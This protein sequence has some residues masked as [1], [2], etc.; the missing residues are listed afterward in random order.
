MNA[1]AMLLAGLF[2][3]F[4]G[5]SRAQE[6]DTGGTGLFVHVGAVSQGSNG[7]GLKGGADFGVS[8]EHRFRSALGI[9]VGA[10]LHTGEL[11]STLDA[12]AI[13]LDLHGRYTWDLARL[14]PYLSAGIG[15][16]HLNPDDLPGTSPESDT[17]FGV[18]VAAGFDVPVRGGWRVGF[19]GAHHFVVAETS[20]GGGGNAMTWFTWAATV[21]FA[22]TGY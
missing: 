3:M 18:P 15:V 22:I 4:A 16:Y 8:F 14:Q 17:N 7:E 9:G 11:T 13:L 20:A 5:A 19:M 21:G 1:K 2:V 12:M 10:A 6:S